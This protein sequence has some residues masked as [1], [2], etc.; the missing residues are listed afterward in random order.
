MEAIELPATG[1]LAW[2]ARIRSP[3][4][5]KTASV[6]PARN[7][8][9][10]AVLPAA[11]ITASASAKQRAEYFRNHL[12]KPGA[13]ETLPTAAPALGRTPAGS[14]G[15]N[16]L[17]SAQDAEG[18]PEGCSVPSTCG[19][20]NGS[21]FRCRSRH[22]DIQNSVRTRAGRRSFLSHDTSNGQTTKGGQNR[23]TSLYS[24]SKKPI[25]GSHPRRA[26]RPV[27]SGP[28]HLNAPRNT[29]LTC[30]LSHLHANVRRSVFLGSG[31]I[32][33]SPK[34]RRGFRL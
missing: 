3:L 22:S 34:T 7:R 14:L 6:T 17:R 12:R 10:C 28:G 32:L 4:L 5:L 29:R 23:L 13:W 16:I 8:T 1:A 31:T 11:S 25:A 26:I 33:F 2:I 20:A 9:L 30:K 19:G 24:L 15:G 18:K 21:R 27:D